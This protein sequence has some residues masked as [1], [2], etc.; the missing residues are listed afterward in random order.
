MFHE[1]ANCAVFNLYNVHFVH[2]TMSPRIQCE[3][4]IHVAPLITVTIPTLCGRFIVHRGSP[5]NE[6]IGHNCASSQLYLETILSFVTIAMK[7]TA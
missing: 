4:L 6:S 1:R 7:L 2:I 5:N 3:Q